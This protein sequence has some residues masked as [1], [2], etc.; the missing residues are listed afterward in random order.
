MRVLYI[1]P[2]SL[3]S[4]SANSIHVINMA[5]AFCELGYQATLVSRR[6]LKDKKELTPLIE[7]AYGHL[8]PSLK[9]VTFYSKTERF[10]SFIIA[11][12]AIAITRSHYDL[13][14]S[15]NIY[16]AFFLYLF[17]RKKFFFETHN[18]EKGFKKYIQKT[19]SSSDRVS[20][21][22]ISKALEELLRNTGDIHTSSQVHVLH[23]AAPSGIEKIELREKNDVRKD[24]LPQHS[25]KT[26]LGYFGHLYPGRGIEIIQALAERN[27]EII[28]LVF[29]GN[30]NIIKELSNK[31]A[32]TNIV[33]MGH[34]PHQ[35]ALIYMKAMDILL[36]PYQ[37]NVFIDN[38]EKMDTSQWMSPI[39][40][41]EYMAS[42]APIISSKLPVLEEVLKDEIN[43]LLVTPDSVEEWDQA[44]KSLLTNKNLAQAIS[45]EAYSQYLSTYSWKARANL[46]LDIYSKSVHS[47]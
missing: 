8:P 44:L 33:I 18:P 28:F 32:N 26:W 31:F 30:D 29:G 16:F 20:I 38:Q 43:S 45:A 47:R 2:S 21:I 10:T 42:N 5:K 34:V 35:K 46:V 17:T 24:I 15:R 40:M 39:K 41:F 9:L 27:S 37:R 19:I 25:S 4:R 11:I 3:P 12:L 13:I 6:T 1:S 36:M 14:F 22:V 23:D 7:Q